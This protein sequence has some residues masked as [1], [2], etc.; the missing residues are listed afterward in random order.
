MEAQAID[1]LG[2]RVLVSLTTVRH[3]LPTMRLRQTSCGSILR[4]S[5]SSILSPASSATSA[6]LLAPPLRNLPVL[7]S[8]T[9]VPTEPTGNGR[10]PAALSPPTPVPTTRLSLTTTR[11]PTPLPL[12]A[13]LPPCPPKPSPGSLETASQPEPARRNDF[14]RPRTNCRM[15]L[16]RPMDQA[17]TKPRIP[18]RAEEANSKSTVGPT[19]KAPPGSRTPTAGTGRETPR[20]P[21]PTPPTGKLASGRSTRSTLTPGRQG[22]ITW[23]DRERTSSSRKK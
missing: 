20:S 17:A 15:P 16:L 23:P 5:G 14:K 11:R 7:A 1:G 8:P 3:Y 22:P 2:I 12:L 4:N 10:K 19:S 21:S 9:A 13:L 6:L 18:P